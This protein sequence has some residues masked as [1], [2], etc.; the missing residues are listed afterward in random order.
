MSSFG[1]S[2]YN[3]N[4]NQQG[5]SSAPRFAITQPTPY[6]D[7]LVVDIILG[8]QHPEY[9][10]D[11][12]N[13]GMARIRFLPTDRLVDIDSLNWVAPL[14]T[15]I[16]EYPLKNELVLVFY[17]L[18]RLFY[19]RRINTTNKLTESSWPGL[20]SK[21]STGTSN[22]ERTNSAVM[23]AQGGLPYGSSNMSS[24]NFSLGD[25]FVENTSVRAVRPN[26][27][28]LIIQGRYGN[29]IRFGSSLF[30]N[31]VARL[32]QPN[33][34]LTVGQDPRSVLS[35]DV[36]PDGTLKPSQFRTRG[37][38]GLTYED[39][40]NDKSSLWM[41][42][43]EEVVLNPATKGTRAHLR[44]AE[45]SDS[46]QYQ[47][48]QIFIN[49]NRVILNSKINEISLFSRA[50]I[51]LSAVKSITIDSN[52][53]VLMTATQDVRIQAENDLSLKGKTVSIVTTQD[54]SHATSGNYI[55]SG[56]KIFIGSQGDESQP[57]VLGGELTVWLDDLMKLLSNDLITS[58]TTLNP[59]PL[60]TKLIELRA[61]L[62]IPGIPQSAIFNSRSNFVSKSN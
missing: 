48:A 15:S 39:I 47:G 16:R 3:V 21:F 10:E 5:A 8:P 44:S 29:I 46:T 60:F 35:T 57:M 6:Q 52:K 41:V 32:P 33:L 17:S 54:I 4:I 1:P 19:T 31:S 14:D 53:S 56:K 18:G 36:N 24:G 37:V 51:N 12:S 62:G 38:Y 9:A 11:G 7:G 20:E 43:D 55:I 13:I 27:G 34:L 58:I 26:E 40:N 61:K 50:E 22:E 28:D 42:A 23:A 2:S 30:S 25:E 45:I 59:T 49:S